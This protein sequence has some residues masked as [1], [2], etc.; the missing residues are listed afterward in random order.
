MFSSKAKI[1]TILLLTLGITVTGLGAV[2]HR[3]AAAGQLSS[4]QRQAEK[5]KDKGDRSLPADK[6]K[7]GSQGTVEVRGRVLDPEGKPMAGARLYLATTSPNG[8][9]P[10]QQATSGPDGRFRFADP[11]SELDKGAAKSPYQVM[12][13]GTG[14]GCDWVAVGSAKEELTLRLVKD[15][16]VRGRILDPDGRP[17]AGARLRVLSVLAA[18]SGDLGGYLESIR[19]GAAHTFAKSWA[20]SLPGQPA[21]VTTGAD[22][23]F[24]LAGIGRE[25]VVRLHLD[26]PAIATADLDVMTRVAAK[27]GGLHGASFDYLAVASRPIRG[28]VR[29]KDTRKPLAGFSVAASGNPW[30]KVVTDKE[31]RYELLGLA[32]APRYDL[33]IKPAAGQLYFLRRAELGDTEGL[34]PLT[35]DIDMVQGLTLRG[36][37]TDRATGK[38]IAQARVEYYPL[39][40]NPYVNRKIAGVWRPESQATTGPDGRYVLTVLPGQGVLIVTGPRTDAYMSSLVTPKEIK[41]FFKAPLFGNQLTRDIGGFGTFLPEHNHA[42][43]LL[44]PDEKGNALV[45][46]VTLEPAKYLTM[47]G[48]VIGP[49]GKPLTGVTAQGL[50]R[51]RFAETTLPGAE[52]TV[53]GLDPR[54]KRQLIFHHKKKNLGHFFT[55]PIGKTPE[56]LI[57][58]LQPCGTASGRLV[59]SSGEPIDGR[60]VLVGGVT[61]EQVGGGYWRIT[62]DKKGRFRAEGLV[63][64]F[65]YH[66]MVDK[67][68]GRIFATAVVEPGKNKD[69]GD[70]K[71]KDN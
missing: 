1:A 46:D 24:T 23:R 15:V 14:H 45:K 64:G 32:K 31:G 4:Q 5:P 12:A 53:E 9:L 69:L 17:V 6:A 54:I 58:K 25:R 27:V 28:V 62:T 33:A 48:R 57:A 39:A 29:D 37:V 59:D 63:P 22:G 49:D 67:V 13:V 68:V 38:P 3:A 35:A 51:Q 65:P 34:T 44:E 21:V 70:L 41:D 43:L 52:F 16:P 36:K 8:E 40:F 50:T 56:P 26:G 66:V 19:K 18:K 47:K 2:W 20:G 55:I 61:S 60:E 11:R 10:S 71:V 30:C 42:L 7:S